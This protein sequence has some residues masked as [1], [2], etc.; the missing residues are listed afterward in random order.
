MTFTPDGE[1]RGYIGAPRVRPN[2]I[3]IYGRASQPESSRR[4]RCC[5]SQSRHS[6]VT[7][8]S[9]GMLMATVSA[10]TINPEEV[11]RR[12]N[13]AGTDVL[14]RRGFFPLPEM[15]GLRTFPHS[16]CIAAKLWHV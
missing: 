15:S 12:L 10:G 4:D 9:R 14:I 6:N 1:F 13:P 16:T 5:F 7:V 11:V 8:D 2:I 3:S